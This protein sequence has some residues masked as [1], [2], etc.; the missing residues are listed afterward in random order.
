MSTANVTLTILT[1]A[2]TTKAAFKR[3]SPALAETTD[4]LWVCT[5]GQMWAGPDLEHDVHVHAAYEG[6]I[7]HITGP[8]F[9]DKTAET[10]IRTAWAKEA[11]P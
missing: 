4:V 9:R 5:C 11:T 3:L 7:H 1:P 8:L 10:T 6:G 2:Q